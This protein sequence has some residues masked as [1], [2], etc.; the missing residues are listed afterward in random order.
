[1]PVSVGVDECAVDEFRLPELHVPGRTLHIYGC[2]GVYHACEVARG[3]KILTQ[4]R[5]YGNMM[6]DHHAQVCPT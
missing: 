3:S 4:I 1:M 5:M 2:R 6:S